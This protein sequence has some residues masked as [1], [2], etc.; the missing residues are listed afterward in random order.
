MMQKAPIIITSPSTRSG[1]TLIQ[2]LITS[3]DNSICYGEHAARRLIELSN[4]V[5][6]EYVLLQKTED[7]HAFNWQ[8]V[9]SGDAN[10]WMVGLE[11]PGEYTQN[12]LV[13]A[14]N[15]FKQ[16][17]DEATRAVDKEIWASKSPKQTFLDIVRLSDFFPQLKCVYIYRNVFDTIRSQKTRGWIKDNSDLANACIEWVANTE[18]I[19]ALQKNNFETV[20]EMLHPVKY[21]SFLQNL[22]TGIQR[23]EEFTGARGINRDIADVKINVWIPTSKDDLTPAINYGEPTALDKGELEIIQKISGARMREI[24]AEY[25][26]SIPEN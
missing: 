14:L 18:V 11:L 16:H 22:D 21:E 19:A 8:K 13:G 12:A 20:P 4:F 17:Y 15:C 25:N 9:L 7:R 23:L 26:G 1:T 24:Y 10:Y 5:H 3:S 6:R 2:R